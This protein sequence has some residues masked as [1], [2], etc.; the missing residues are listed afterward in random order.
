MV[1]HFWERERERETT[2]VGRGREKGRGDTESEAGFR[3]WAVST[4]S[5]AGFGP[6]HDLSWSWPSHPGS[7]ALKVSLMVESHNKGL[8]KTKW[9]MTQNKIRANKP[10]FHHRRK[11]TSEQT[12]RNRHETRA[13]LSVAEQVAGGPRVQ[14]S[15]QDLLQ[16]DL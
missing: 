14:Q 9:R 1:I 5:D 15:C 6:D 2:G 4:D 3:L 7:P 11:P 12:L 10:T 8:Y 13:Y 16:R